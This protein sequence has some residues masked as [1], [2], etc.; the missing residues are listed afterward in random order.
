MTEASDAFNAL[1]FETRK[2]LAQ[3]H[4]ETRINT[5]RTVREILVRRH[6]QTLAEIDKWIANCEEPTPAPP[7]PVEIGE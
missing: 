4:N 7:M 2:L 3:G 6:K 1:P 5:I